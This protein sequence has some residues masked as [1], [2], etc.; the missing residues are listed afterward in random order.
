MSLALMRATRAGSFRGRP[1]PYCVM[2]LASGRVF[3][4][5]HVPHSCPGRTAAHADNLPALHDRYGVWCG[6]EPGPGACGTMDPGSAAHHFV[7]RLVRGTK[8][9]STSA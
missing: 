8:W 5:R 6:A 2:K 4:L 9:R 1:K 7:L 3:V